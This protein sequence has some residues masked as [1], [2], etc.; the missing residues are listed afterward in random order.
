MLSAVYYLLIQM[1]NVK[2]F[3]C[4]IIGTPLK[5]QLECDSKYQ[6]TVNF[7]YLQPS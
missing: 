7:L 5:Y 6:L 3:F 4:Q 1:Q 2:S